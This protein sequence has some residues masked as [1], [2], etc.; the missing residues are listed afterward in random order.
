MRRLFLATAIL[1][2]AMA[3][4]GADESDVLQGQSVI[5]GQIDA[6]RSGDNERAYSYAA[7]NIKAIFPSVD[8]FMGM[9]ANG[10]RPVQMPRSFAFGRSRELEGGKVIAQEVLLVGPDGKDYVALYV[11]QRA[12]DGSWKIAGVQIVPGKAQST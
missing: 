3:S 6:F 2:A 4:A 9:V 5:T 12:S 7:P 8:R 10:Y 1:W 11:L